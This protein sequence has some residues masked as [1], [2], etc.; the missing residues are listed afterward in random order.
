MKEKNNITQVAKILA[1]T[2]DAFGI[3]DM[4]KTI[5]IA[6]YSMMLGGSTTSLL[7]LLNNL[8]PEE[9]EIDLQLQNNTG[10]FLNQVPTYVNLLPP[11]N[12]YTGIKGKLLKGLN[13]VFSGTAIK[14]WWINRKH[15]KRGTN[16]QIWEDFSARHF[17]RENP[18]EYDIAIGFLE[19]WPVRYIAY[20]I[21]A[22]KK[23]GWLHS[24]FSKLAPVPELEKPWMERVNQIVFV[25]EDCRNAFATEMPEFAEKAITIPNI[26][27]STLLRERAEQTEETDEDF[28]QFRDADCF[29]L[30]TVCRINIS[31]KGLDRTVACAKQLKKQGRKFLW[32][33]VG[34]GKD[35]TALHDLIAQANVADC[36]IPVGSRM[37]PLPF[38]A[39]ADLFCML[40]RY[41]GK[42]MVV[43]E[44]MIL[45]TPPLVTHYLSAEEQIQNGIEGLIVENAENTALEAILKCMDQPEM[46]QS[47]KEYLLRHEYGNKKDIHTITQRYF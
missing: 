37:N 40:S 19:G 12:I 35:M 20:N 10:P 3:Y 2:E 5:L 18:K 43:T 1:L 28:V 46:V 25:A 36:V 47:M 22:K 45:G 34:D 21:H 16:G 33:I 41:E 8:S 38:I 14:A 23:L 15:G 24:T 9:Y 26:I 13:Y 39:A 42:P 17:S 11:A 32:M 44:S 30:V 4:R 27:D 29:K 6:Y 31:V 7:A